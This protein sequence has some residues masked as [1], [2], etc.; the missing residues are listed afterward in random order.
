MPLM[1]DSQETH[2]VLEMARGLIQL[3]SK[4]DA[5]ALEQ[6]GASMLTTCQLKVLT[7]LFEGEN[8]KEI[9]QALYLS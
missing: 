6:K 8:V 9:G 7:L 1:R 3:S 5:P 2:D 4:K